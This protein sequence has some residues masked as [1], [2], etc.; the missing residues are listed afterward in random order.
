MPVSG[1][2]ISGSAAAVTTPSARRKRGPPQDTGPS[3]E[4]SI[5]EA[6]SR[7]LDFP[8]AER[9]SYVRAM[10]SRTL[11]FKREGRSIEAIREALPEFAR[12][13]GHLFEM[14]TGEEGFDANHL[15]MMLTML[16]RM[17]QGS[18]THH[19]ATTIVGDR[20]MKKFV[21]P[22]DGQGR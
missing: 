8:A 6:E 4:D 22:S 21:R 11:Q 12:D 19:Q 1:N 5:R 20:T 14:I 9:A 3:L 16:D 13:Y 10:V 7:A 17:G 15:N 2:D 18:L